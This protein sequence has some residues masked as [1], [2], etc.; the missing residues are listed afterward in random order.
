MWIKVN[1]QDGPNFTIPVPLFLAG[2]RPVINMLTRINGPEATWYAPM[3]GD[4]VNELRRYEGTR[5][6]WGGENILG[7]D[8]SGLP[9]KALRN[10]LLKGAFIYG[11]RRCLRLALQN[12]WLDASAAALANGYQNYVTWLE[13]EGTVSDICANALSPGDLAITEDGVHVMVFLGE[14][15]WISADPIQGKV[16]IESSAANNPWFKEKVKFYTWTVLLPYN[17]L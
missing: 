3:A 15:R 17:N 6:I 1:T 7:I 2:T 16:I 14:D 10:A 13:K 4:I 8:C 11:E 12:W 9:R 5:Y